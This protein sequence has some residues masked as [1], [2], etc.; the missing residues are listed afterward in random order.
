MDKMKDN[1]LAIFLFLF[2]CGILHAESIGARIFHGR[3]HKAFNVS[4]VKY[5]DLK[6]PEDDDSGGGSSRDS[7]GAVSTE[8][9]G[10]DS[11]G[12]SG[13]DSKKDM[14]NKLK[15]KFGDKD[16]SKALNMLDKDG[17]GKK[18]GIEGALN[19]GGAGDGSLAIDSSKN[20][21]ELDAN[22]KA[23]VKVHWINAKRN[24]KNKNFDRSLEEIK[25]ILSVDPE[26]GEAHLMRASISAKRKAFNEAWKDLEK[27]RK[28]LA[29][30]PKLTDFEAKLTKASPKPENLS[31]A[32]GN[33]SKP[34]HVSDLAMDAV[35]DL[36]LDKDFASKLSGFSFGDIS[37]S[38]GKVGVIFKLKGKDKLDSAELEKKIKDVSKQDVKDVKAADDGKS[39]EM[40]VII[41]DI[42]KDNPELK[43]IREVAQFMKDISEE[44]DIKVDQSA[45]GSPDKDKFFDVTY[46]LI[47]R[48]ISEMN[49]FLRK[50]SP[51]SKNYSLEKLESTSFGNQIA[52]KGTVKFRFKAE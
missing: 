34:G 15:S 10:D 43:A 8:P 19:A 42:P 45:E 35:E 23:Y 49:G 37:E 38:E 31:G 9:S 52:L 30:D 29:A 2:V 36:L 28:K 40:T 16:I 47:T 3:S 4:E 50:I 33:R 14:L 26:N 41:A 44:C 5:Y 32:G 11:G 17:T 21:G 18:L 39:V 20:T 48:G 1:I 25:N 6:K 46:T 7:S 27:A 51:Y 22:D 13:G 12:N 24:Y